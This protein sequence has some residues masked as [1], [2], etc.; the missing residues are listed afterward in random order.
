MSWIS[1]NYEKAAVGGAA[2]VA[3]AFVGII[4]KNKDA[5]DEATVIAPVKEKKD[6]SVAGMPAVIATK[7][8]LAKAHII[9]PPDVDGRKVDLMTGVPLFAKKDDTSACLLYTSPSP[10]D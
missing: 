4:V 1:E 8:S 6:L 5:I 2:I 10:R 3:L 9:T 7:A